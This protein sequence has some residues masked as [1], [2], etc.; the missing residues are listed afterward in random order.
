MSTGTYPHGS[1]DGTM[2]LDLSILMLSSRICLRRELP[3]RS[4]RWRR[5]WY[6][7][8]RV[9]LYKSPGYHP[10]R[11]R[12]QKR[13]FHPLTIPKPVRRAYPG[14]I[15]AVTA[16]RPCLHISAGKDILPA[17]N[18]TRG[19]S[20]ARIR[21]SNRKSRWHRAHSYSVFSFPDYLSASS[22]L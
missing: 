14:C 6:N 2:P 3:I 17:W 12:H 16:M 13:V 22:P 18:C 10:F 4:R 5:G 8:Y 15:K 11:V 1:F 7:R 9:L 19:S 21:S 20:T